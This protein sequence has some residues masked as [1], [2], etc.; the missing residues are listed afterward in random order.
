MHEQA[1]LFEQGIQALEANAYGLA[2][3]LFQAYLQQHPNH[4]ESLSNLA[5]AYYFQQNYL[6]AAKQ[7]QQA[8]QLSWDSDIAENVSEV[9]LL[10]SQGSHYEAALPFYEIVLPH[11]PELNKHYFWALR[12][13]RYIEKAEQFI[14]ALVQRCP[15]ALEYRLLDVFFLPQY[16]LSLENMHY[17]HRR[18]NQRLDKLLA[19]LPLPQQTSAEIMVGSPLFDLMLLGEDEKLT[20]QKVSQVW[21]SLFVNP[22]SGLS[23]H[24]LPKKENQVIRLAWVSFSVYK[25]STMDYFRS[26]LLYFAQK[27]GFETAI[28]YFGSPEDALT[29][30]LAAAVDYYQHLDTQDLER[31]QALISAWQADILFYLDIGQEAFLYTL[32]HYRLAPIQCT[33]AGIP[34]TTGIAT[35]DYYFSSRVFELPEAQDFYSEKLI[36]FENPPWQVEVAQTNS[37]ASRADYGLS[38][39]ALV[40]LFPHTLFRLDPE[41]D[42]V[43]E[44]ILREV[45]DSVIVFIRYKQSQLHHLIKQRILKRFPDIDSARLLDLSWMSQDRFLRLLQLSDIALDSFYLGGGLVTYQC[46]SMGLPMIHLP[47]PYLRCRIAAGLYSQLD[48]AQ[49]IA[50]N[51]DDYIDKA[52]FLGRNRAPRQA[53]K[54]E[55]Q[56]NQAKLFMNTRGMDELHDFFVKCCYK[57]KQ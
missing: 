1:E 47:S 3:S 26:L 21:Q 19:E 52:L 54:K 18:L 20:L 56:D 10:L 36:A 29:H 33:S 27:K 5:L 51:K 9:A 46:F 15:D 34:I 13:S 14:D 44:Q 25:H 49:W 41:M 53:L 4:L 17:W 16:Y 50:A 22:N 43:F 39:T 48:Q 55:I 40:Y 6:L 2:E 7:W 12:Y 23:C 28:F 31:A 57:D 42:A 11:Y 37:T 32:A 8:L 30:E 45:P 38:E 35:M 24:S